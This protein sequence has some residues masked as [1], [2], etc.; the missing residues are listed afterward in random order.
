M[1]RRSSMPNEVNQY[2]GVDRSY[3]GTSDYGQVVAFFRWEREAETGSS[4]VEKSSSRHC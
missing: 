4:A 1:L 2:A 3:V